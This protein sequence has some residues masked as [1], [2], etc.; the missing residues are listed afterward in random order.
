AGQSEGQQA[1]S[2]VHRHLR[3]LLEH[4]HIGEATSE[5]RAGQERLPCIP[6]LEAGD[7]GEVLGKTRPSSDGAVRAHD[8][9]EGPGQRDER[10]VG[11]GPVLRTQEGLREDPMDDR[12]SAPRWATTESYRFDWTK[13]T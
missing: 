6:E 9:I 3:P 10:L 13:A 4:P 5:G 2:C 8:L 1:A 7:R 11:G 12:P